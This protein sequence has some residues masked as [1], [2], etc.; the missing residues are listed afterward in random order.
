M[1][2]SVTMHSVFLYGFV[3]IC[4]PMPPYI[5]CGIQGCPGTFY[6]KIYRHAFSEYV[7]PLPNQFLALYLMAHLLQK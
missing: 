1:S 3:P 5:F 4:I 7:L 6:Y 2:L